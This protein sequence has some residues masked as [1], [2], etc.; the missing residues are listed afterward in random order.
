MQEAKCFSPKHND[1]RIAYRNGNYPLAERLAKEAYNEIPNPHSR[2]NEQVAAYAQQKIT[3]RDL[4]QWVYL[5][6]LELGGHGRSVLRQ[7]Y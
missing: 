3:K 1:G 5:L 4:D 2:L 7:G 6:K